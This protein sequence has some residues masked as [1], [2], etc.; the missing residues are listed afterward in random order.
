V[1]HHRGAYCRRSRPRS[2]PGF[3]A[4]SVYLWTLPMF[5]CDGW[6]FTW[7]ATAAGATHLCL[8]AIDPGR[9]WELLR[10][11]GVT[12]FSAA[13]TVLTMI[14]NAPEATAGPPLVPPVQVQTG[15]A[16]PSPTLIARMAEAG[17]RVTH[18]YGLTETYGPVAINDWHPDWNTKPPAEQAVLQ[19]RQGVGNV[20]ASGSGCVDPD[21]W[22]FSS[23]APPSA[24]RLPGQRRVLGYYR[25]GGD[26]RG[27]SGAGSAGP[28]CGGDAY[29]ECFRTA[30]G[31]LISGGGIS[32]PGGGAGWAPSRGCCRPG[33]GGPTTSGVRRPWRS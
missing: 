16:P 10:T 3:A 14:V 11:R 12:H 19:A 6:C 15:G 22:M 26:C 1:Y 27:D 28:A 30:Q 8:R 21:G 2:T 4:D 7:A 18:L 17:L 32:P 5:H 25:E 29:T 9:I 20:I 24:A 13:P 33:S 23:M 31:R